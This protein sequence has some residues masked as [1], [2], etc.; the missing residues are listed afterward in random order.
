LRP[1]RRVGEELAPGDAFFG[2]RAIHAG[3]QLLGHRHEHLDHRRRISSGY[4]FGQQRRRQASGV[5]E[6]D[7]PSSVQLLSRQQLERIDVTG[8][9]DSEVAAIQRRQ[10]RFVQPFDDREHRRVNEPDVRVGVPIADLGD[11]PVVVRSQV[12]DRVGAT[13]DVFEQSYKHAGVEGPLDQV[14]E[15]DQNRR[16]DQQRLVC[17]FNEAPAAGVIIITP[18]E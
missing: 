17:L 18:I 15:L 1:D 11:P 5:L 13:V 16:R 4:P 6:T 8:S 12:D 10:L 2:G 9:Q 14:V 7:A 3:E